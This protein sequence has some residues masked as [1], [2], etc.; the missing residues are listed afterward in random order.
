MLWGIFG[1]KF[2]DGC[3]ASGGGE[4]GEEKRVI[5]K[6]DVPVVTTYDAFENFTRLNLLCGHHK[7]KIIFVS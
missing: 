1:E 3:C 2:P 5:L 4:G 7:R 6:T